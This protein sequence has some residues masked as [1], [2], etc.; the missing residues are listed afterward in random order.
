MEHLKLPSLEEILSLYEGRMLANI[1]AAPVDLEIRNRF[2]RIRGHVDSACQSL[3]GKDVLTDIENEFCKNVYCIRLVD[4]DTPL[5][6]VGIRSIYRE[7]GEEHDKVSFFIFNDMLDITDTE[8][9]RMLSM[10]AAMN[11]PNCLAEFDF[12]K[13]E[14][15][16]GGYGLEHRIVHPS[17]RG[18]GL[19][20][21]LLSGSEAFFEKVGE[22]NNRTISIF[23]K[24]GQIDVMHFLYNA[25]FSIESIGDI[26]R[27]V[28]I[29]SGD[30]KYC[31]GEEK[32]VFK[33]TVPESR[34][35][36]GDGFMHGEQIM[37]AKKIK[38]GCKEIHDDRRRYSD[39]IRSLE[40]K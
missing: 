27:L 8:Y 39:Q 1:A 9:M 5:Y 10:C 37:F 25:G 28:G 18:N 24:V 6:L 21:L 15:S 35:T 11:D 34:R 23:A 13:T 12:V 14:N 30:E 33:T 19:G 31:L 3:L 2:E 20:T 16:H 22:K 26:D 4:P 7:P 29:M 38:H 17:F 32:Y 36:E 40:A